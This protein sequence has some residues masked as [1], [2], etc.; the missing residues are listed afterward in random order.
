MHHEGHLA[1]IFFS[2][3]L[4][5][6]WKLIMMLDFL[7]QLQK[8]EEKKTWEISFLDSNFWNGKC[9]IICPVMAKG[10]Q[11]TK[12]EWKIK[13]FVLYCCNGLPC[14]FN[15]VLQK[16]VILNPSLV[17]VRKCRLSFIQHGMVHMH[18]LVWN[19]WI[20]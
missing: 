12:M 16:G 1:G 17:N 10:C 11:T 4:V 5:H 9:G 15:T 19:N 3:Q 14:V 20:F 8:L 13:F 18:Y 2:F 7:L 6:W